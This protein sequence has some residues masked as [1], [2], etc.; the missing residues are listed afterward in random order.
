MELSRGTCGS[1]NRGG[2]ELKVHGLRIQGGRMALLS[3]RAPIELHEVRVAVAAGG[4]GSGSG[5]HPRLASI[6]A[7]PGPSP[8]PLPMFVATSLARSVDQTRRIGVGREPGA[9]AAA[10]GPA[11]LIFVR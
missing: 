4:G 6:G 11:D 9:V 3:R 10:C 1:G 8:P 7:G 2:D 5:S